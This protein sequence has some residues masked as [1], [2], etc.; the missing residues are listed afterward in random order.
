M[1]LLKAISRI[2]TYDKTVSK[3]VIMINGAELKD[4]RPLLLKPML[5][6]M[7]TAIYKV[8]KLTMNVNNLTYTMLVLLMVVVVETAGILFLCLYKK[9]ASITHSVM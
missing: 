4:L 2:R 7:L 3:Y 8:V 9:M 5:G 1:G 6:L